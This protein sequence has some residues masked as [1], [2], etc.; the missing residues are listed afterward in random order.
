MRFMRQKVFMTAL[1]ISVPRPYLRSWQVRRMSKD[2]F[3]GYKNKL[4]G[5]LY[6]L[7]CEKEKS[8]EWEKFLN[9]IIIELMGLEDSDSI[10]Y[11]ALMGKLHSLRF[12]SYEYFRKTVF[13]CI[14]LVRGLVI[15]DEYES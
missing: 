8:G 1:G 13:E 15:N 3:E 14:N 6:G 7:L 12:L 4:V 9:T 5:R 2:T 11:W 10:N